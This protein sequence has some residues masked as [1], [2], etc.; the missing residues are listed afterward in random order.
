MRILHFADAHID[1]VTQGRHDPATGFAVRTLDFLAALD[2]IVNTAIEE[3]PDLVIF[4]G[5]AYKDRTPVPTFQREWGRRVAR[6]SQAGIPTLLLVG[7]HD[8]SPAAGRAHALQEFETLAIPFVRV[9]SKPMFLGPEEL[10]APIQVLAIPWVSR[11]SLMAIKELSGEDP[12]EIY[13]ALEQRLTDLVNIWLDR[14]DKELP[15]ILA[16]HASVQGA[17]YGGERSVML[18]SDLVLPGSLVKDPRL[19]YVALG[20]IHKAQDV[21]QGLQPPVIY[22]GS[23]ERVDFGEAGDEKFFVI[24]HIETG[25]VTEVEWRKL[26]GRR[27]IDR[28]LRLERSTDIYEQI[29][30]VLP[31][32]EEMLNSVLRLVLEYP[33][34]WDGMIDEQSLRR[35]TEGCL[36]FH[37]I[38]RPQRETRLRI[39]QNQEIS[40]LGPLDLLDLFLHTLDT[41]DVEAEALRKLAATVIASVSGMES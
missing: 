9:A 3:R 24:A 20:H 17:S 28:L 36:E 22:P 38:R 29:L 16:A 1:M 11:S 27:F 34:E 12:A 33:F 30:A 26:D 19:S 32:Q 2:T 25:K 6:L 10:G 18:G 37:F 23:I 13:S 14:A 31:A 40:S 5:D 39:P 4:A 35:Y 7:N 41:A 15:V 21:N 8:L